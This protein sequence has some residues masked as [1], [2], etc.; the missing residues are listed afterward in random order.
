MSHTPIFD[1]LHVSARGTCVHCAVLRR[2]LHGPGLVF[3]TEKTGRAW[4]A[5]LIAIGPGRADD[6][7]YEN[8]P[9][10]ETDGPGLKKWARA[11]L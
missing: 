7:T 11:D 6:R 2:S 10:L 8:G 4:P 3:A 9:G 5:G 1:D